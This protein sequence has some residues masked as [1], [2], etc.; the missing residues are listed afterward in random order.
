[1]FINIVYFIERSNLHSAPLYYC[2]FHEKIKST[3]STLLDDKIRIVNSTQSNQH[4]LLYSTLSTSLNDQIHIVY[5]IQRLNLH[6]IT[7]YSTKR[8]NL[9]YS[10]QRPNS[11]CL[12]H[13]LAWQIHIIYST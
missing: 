13:S 2:L 12:L 8:L 4:C 7:V 11:H 9:H 1:M 3:L 5:S 10:T 6:Y